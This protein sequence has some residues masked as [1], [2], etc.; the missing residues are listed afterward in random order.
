MSRKGGWYGES[1]RHSEARKKGAAAQRSSR[2]SL[3]DT[4]TPPAATQPIT[5]GKPFLETFKK[6]DTGTHFRKSESA[7]RQSNVSRTSEKPSHPTPPLHTK[8]GDTDRNII[9]KPIKRRTR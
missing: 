7:A 9:G 3:N 1:A 8:Y 6:I 5:D 2:S 4:S